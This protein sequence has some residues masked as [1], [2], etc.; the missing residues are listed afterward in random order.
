MGFEGALPFLGMLM[1]ILIQVGNLEVS[2]AAMSA[3]ANKYI[4]AV[5]SN[6]L[7]TLILLP[8]SFICCRSFSLYIHIWHCFPSCIEVNLI[9]PLLFILNVLWLLMT[10]RS[11]RPP[12]VTFSVLCRIFLLSLIGLVASIIH[13]YAI[14]LINLLVLLI[15]CL[16]KLSTKKVTCFRFHLDYVDYSF[17]KRERE[18]ERGS[19]DFC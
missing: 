1:V 18:R 17:T 8:L 16:K 5:Y 14:I 3:G 11:Q 13:T 4:L 9:F 6:A 19:F 12:P 2:K 10:V 15:F 7:S